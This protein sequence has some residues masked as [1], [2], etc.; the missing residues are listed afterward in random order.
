MCACAVTKY[1]VCVCV[2]A[3]MYTMR[4]TSVYNYID[5]IQRNVPLQICKAFQ[6]Y[7]SGLIKNQGSPDARSTYQDFDA[8][9]P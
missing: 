4:L 9:T 5:L 3:H 1:C 7:V 2:C 6:T 8:V